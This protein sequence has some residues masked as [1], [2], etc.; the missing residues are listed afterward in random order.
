M[1][2]ISHAQ[3]Q[4]IWDEEHK[5]PLV[6]KQMD[7][8]DASSGVQTFFEFLTT[9]NTPI[10]K[11]IEMGCGKGRNSIWLSERGVNEM[12]GFDFS[13]HA[14]AEATKRAQ[15]RGVQDKTVFKT[16]DATLPWP[17]E[18]NYFD[19]GIDC[20]ASTDIESP[21][22]RN[23]AIQ[24][25][26]RVIK[27]GGYALGYVLSS[28]DQYHTEISLNS[29]GEE[30]NSFLH[31]VTGKFEKTFTLG[32][33]KELYKDFTLIEQKML[34]KTTEFFGKPYECINFWCVFQKS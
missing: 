34:H 21:D 23:F 20:F 33:I 19:F 32:E 9:H 22:G 16:Q 6:L 30:A 2:T 13:P 11:G 26:Y 3:Q 12:H 1:K 29:P 25:M 10:Q 14:V 7:S 5:N 27:P 4:A 17:Y 8:S 31:P 28:D 24:E 18:S 15:E